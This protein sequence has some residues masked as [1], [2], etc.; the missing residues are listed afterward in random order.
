[1]SIG[2]NASGWSGWA[3]PRGG[4]TGRKIETET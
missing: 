4:R 1:M 3:G 2:P